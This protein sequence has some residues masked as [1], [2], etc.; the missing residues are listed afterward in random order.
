MAPSTHEFHRPY[1]SLL[2][3]AV[4]ALHKL[5]H[6]STPKSPF[7]LVRSPQSGHNCELGACSLRLFIAQ[8]AQYEVDVLYEQ[9]GE[10][11]YERF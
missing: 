5:A 10:P 6:N 2:D 4:Y 8:Q 11:R 9:T 3:D 1:G 7:T